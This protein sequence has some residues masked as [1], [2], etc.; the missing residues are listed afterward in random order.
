MIDNNRPAY[1]ILAVEGFFGPDDHLYRAGECIYFDDEPNEEMEPL[2]GL[3]KEKLNGHLEKLDDLAREWAAK[4]NR[5]FVGRPRSFD[6]ALE[7][8][9]QVQ[10]DKMAI[11]TAPKE[12][13]TIERVEEDP[14]PEVGTANPKRGRGRP[15]KNVQTIASAA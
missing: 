7:L 13:K 5:P 11:M 2:N 12:V 10:R 14:V 4:T 15:A 1:R 9:T 6:G 8:A 3:A